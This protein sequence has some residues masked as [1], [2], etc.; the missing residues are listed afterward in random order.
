M[1]HIFGP[2]FDRNIRRFFFGWSLVIDRKIDEDHSLL[3]ES[4]IDVNYFC[5]AATVVY[6]PLRNSGSDWFPL[7]ISLKSEAFGCLLLHFAKGGFEQVLDYGWSHAS[8]SIDHELYAAFCLDEYAC[9]VCQALKQG[10]ASTC[11]CG[12]DAI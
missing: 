9:R 2:N 1:K 6:W 8:I 11:S 12:G 7:P 3:F 10:K 4:G 5:R